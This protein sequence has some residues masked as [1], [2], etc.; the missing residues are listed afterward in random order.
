[1]NNIEKY[2]AFVTGF[3]YTFSNIKSSGLDIGF[4]SEYHFD[5]RNNLPIRGFNN[6]LFIGSRLRFNDMQNTNLLLGGI[7]DLKN[8]GQIWGVE[9]SRRMGDSWK[10]QLE[11][12]FL[13]NISKDEFLYFFRQD[14]F[15]QIKLSK[16]F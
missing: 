14:G 12:R 15:S 11:I 4:L 8:K 7:I 9:A 2:G 1:M 10:L 5:S 16:F 13:Q 3:E 6:D